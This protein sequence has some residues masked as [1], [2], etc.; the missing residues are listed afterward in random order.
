VLN[1][2]T[3]GPYLA[4]VIGGGAVLA[5]A[6]AALGGPMRPPAALLGVLLALHVGDVMTGSHLQ[7]STVFSYSPT[8]GGRF[9]GFGNLTFGQVSA[10]A[11]LLA[12]LVA[13]L[14]P[15]RRGVPFAGG[16]PIVALPA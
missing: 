15:G 7:F 10:A 12:G 16:V 11:V 9:A 4:L 6:A 2:D 1:L 13:Y 3:V 5:A 14:V 8:V